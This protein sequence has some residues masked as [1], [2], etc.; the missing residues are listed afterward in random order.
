VPTTVSN[1]AAFF[2]TPPVKACVAMAE[3]SLDLGGKRASARLAQMRAT[4]MP[5]R[6]PRQ[7]KLFHSIA[8]CA[9]R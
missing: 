7:R 5:R 2:R 6:P 9:S 1:L 3:F 8:D 4:T